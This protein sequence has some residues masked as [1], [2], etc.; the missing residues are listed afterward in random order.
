MIAF[1]YRS[2]TGQSNARAVAAAEV[3]AHRAEKLYADLKD[4]TV[5][6]KRAEIALEWAYAENKL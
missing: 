2:T 1:F 4:A 3:A 6:K 5:A